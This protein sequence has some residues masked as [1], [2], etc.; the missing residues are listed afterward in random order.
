M[1]EYTQGS[2]APEDFCQL[3]VEISKNF[4]STSIVV[5][6][7][8]EAGEFCA[9]VTRHLQS[10][11][12]P[13]GTIKTLLASRNEVDIRSVL[14]D[15]ASISIAAR[16]GD[17]QLYVHSEIQTRK[18]LNK[19]HIQEPELIG[20]IVKVLTEG[21]DGMFRW[22]ACQ[23]DYLCGCS[24]DRDRREALKKLPPDLPKSYDRIL[25]RVNKSSKENQALVRHT[26]L[27]VVHAVKP[28]TTTQL[29]QA[30]AVRPG[31]KTFERRNMITLDELLKWCS[32]LVRKSSQSDYLELAHFTVKEY[33]HGH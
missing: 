20:H 9:D 23:M 22:V 12:Q 29:L 16:S 13:S 17:L 18:K 32:S 21:A 5:N 25:E 14:T 8:D 27:W 28:P 6:G 4:I 31:D 1:T 2:A 30:L 19:L 11:N 7:L 10:L 3:I 33:L 24:T 26:L 15:Y